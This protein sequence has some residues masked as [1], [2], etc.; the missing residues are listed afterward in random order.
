MNKIE[1]FWET[2]YE[3]AKFLKNV[4]G[5]KYK[6]KYSLSGSGIYNLIYIN[7]DIYELKYTQCKRILKNDNHLIESN[8]KI[9]IDLIT[10][11]LK[12]NREKIVV[13]SG[14]IITFPIQQWD[15]KVEIVKKR[16]EPQ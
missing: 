12:C 5:D 10:K 13:N 14:K 2:E 15:A 7:N 8:K 3:F 11:N 9:I 16:K 4:F 6:R 1:Y